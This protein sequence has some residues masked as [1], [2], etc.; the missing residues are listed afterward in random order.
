MNT[1]LI[2]LMLCI[3]TLVYLLG[4]QIDLMDVDAAQYASIS[5][6][7]L[8]NKSFL[9]VYDL[10]R[11]Y[12][13]KPPM[14][15][16]LSALSMKIFGINHFAYRL[17][18]FIFA[19]LAIY[20]TYRLA[21]L[22]YKKEVALLAALILASCQAMF[23]ILHDVRT[24]TMLMGW[25]ICG[26][27][28]LAEW[29][30]NKKFI[31]FTLGCIAIAG[32]MMTKGP[33]ALMVPVFALG[34]DWI[35]KRDWKA[36]VR[37]EY[38]LG[39]IIIAILVL[40]MSYG[41]YQQFDMHPE[42]VLYNQNNVSGLR[43]FYW[44]QSFGRITGESTWKEYGSFSFLLQ[45]MLWSFLPWIIFFLTAI[46]LEGYQ[47][48]KQRL[49]IQDN[50]EWIS[51]GGFIITYCA[52]GSSQAQLP[53]YIFI[54]FPFAAIVTA[55]F[56]YTLL[57]ENSYPKLQNI[58]SIIHKIL[59]GL[60]WIA[61]IVLL[62]W[63]FVQL[64]KTAA[65]IALVFFAAFI[66]MLFAK[67]L[68]LPRILLLGA[69]TIMGINLFLNTAF[70]PALLQ[71]QAGSVAGRFITKNHLPTSK[72]FIYDFPEGRSFH[73]YGQSVF[74]HLD[75]LQQM[76]KGDIILTDRNNLTAIDSA[77]FKVT[78]LQQ[79]GDY[80]ISMLSLRFLNPKKREGQLQKYVL[81]KLD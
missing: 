15:F 42:K 45:N 34:S 3:C 69:F 76:K 30:Q 19:L 80:H 33:L 73:F 32:G 50:Q 79:G 37:W 67:K 63:P 65:L 21:R 13:D 78:V 62:W 48:I 68:P 44:T 46:V 2:V 72:V 12:L 74:A 8:A 57:F 61:L 60:L 22:Y 66:V 4:M 52:L 5:R 31:P 36:F 23:L 6:E 16:W 25:V 26:I 71:Y 70:Y 28:Q 11:D 53:H 41:L 40:P 9:Q 56:L 29:K 35:L 47:L 18:S 27:W 55:K 10:G 20:S 38:I 7:M 51:T 58:L 14:L 17:P 54:A 24:D 59:F 75:S 64:T 39:I 77:G 49:N 81:A 43:F 1:R